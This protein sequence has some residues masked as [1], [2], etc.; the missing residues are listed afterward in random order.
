MTPGSSRPGEQLPGDDAA[1]ERHAVRDV[2]ASDLVDDEALSWGDERDASHVSAREAERAPTGAP[3]EPQVMGSGAL[4]AHGVLGG[5][6]LLASV[7]WLVS[8]WRFAYVF[9]DPAM[10]LLW[11]LGVGLAVLAPV[12]W[13]TASIVLVPA[14]RVR[15]RLVVMAVGVLV[16]APWPFVVGAFA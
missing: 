7:G 2:P 12:L 11:R 10:T 14:A 3:D 1:A 4:V 15:R 8:A 13:F 6:S 5:A 9:A 16:V